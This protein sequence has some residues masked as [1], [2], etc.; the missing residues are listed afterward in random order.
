MADQKNKSNTDHIQRRNLMNTNVQ[1]IIGNFWLWLG[2]GVLLVSATLAVKE[3]SRRATIIP[4]TGAPEAAVNSNSSAQT[5]PEAGVQG[6]ND[7]IL[8]HSNSS[9]QAVPEAGVQSVTDYIRLHNATLPA[10]STDPAV[11]SVMDYL[12]AHGIQP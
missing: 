12:K 7:Y 5:V 10:V 8:A 1:R 3:V 4:I 6:V 2:I 11:K 9:A